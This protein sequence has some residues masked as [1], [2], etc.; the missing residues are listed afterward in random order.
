[1]YGGFRLTHLFVHQNSFHQRL[2]SNDA[3]QSHARRNDLAETI[4]PDHAVVNIHGQETWK[5]ILMEMFITPAVEVR[6]FPKSILVPSV[7]SI[8]TFEIGNKEAFGNPPAKNTP[9]FG[10]VSKHFT[11]KQSRFPSLLEED[12]IE[13]SPSAKEI[14]PSA[15]SFRS[16]DKITAGTGNPY[17]YTSKKLTDHE[18]EDAKTES[19][20]SRSVS[21]MRF[22]LVWGIGC[23]VTFSVVVQ[24]TKCFPDPITP[25]SNSLRDPEDYE[26]M[27]EL[28]I[29]ERRGEQDLFLRRKSDAKSWDQQF[30]SSEGEFQEREETF[31]SNNPEKSEV[32]EV[33]NISSTS[34]E[35]FHYTY[36][37]EPCRY[38]LFSSE[39][40]ALEKS[41]DLKDD[42]KPNGTEEPSIYDNLEDFEYGEVGADIFDSKLSPFDDIAEMTAAVQRHKLIIIMLMDI[43]MNIIQYIQYIPI[44]QDIP[45]NQNIQ[46]IPIIQ[47]IQNIPIIQ[48]I[49]NIPI[50]QDIPL[51]QNIQDIPIIQNIPIIQDIPL[52]QNI[53]DIPI[54]QNIQNIPILNIIRIPCG[55]LT[56]DFLE[57]GEPPA[58]ET[59]FLTAEN[60]ENHM[61]P[62]IEEKNHESHFRQM[63][64]ASREIQ[65]Q[66]HP[67]FR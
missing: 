67:L 34:S 27:I 40:S 26:E 52:I 38:S 21:T 42:F 7:S 63:Q 6:A 4:Q 5:S 37:E 44:I 55:T 3:A 61:A 59:P 45:L 36:A 19:D 15:T 11:V 1:M 50:I 35:S 13:F 54:I 58:G 62:F 31:Y 41:T 8:V 46:D 17:I 24:R 47:N 56:A 2:W 51:I 23:Y 18:D 39:L 22:V 49:Q 64:N 43:L 29:S 25:D 32:L 12:G 33:S 66:N 20:G 10:K 14:H 65:L 57:I 48:N 53:Q 30:E 9:S 60:L 28:I 16:P